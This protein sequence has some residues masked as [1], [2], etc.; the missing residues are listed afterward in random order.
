MSE[1]RNTYANGYVLWWEFEVILI[2]LYIFLNEVWR[3]EE[4]KEGVWNG[5]FG[6]W[7]GEPIRL[8]SSRTLEI[9]RVLGQVFA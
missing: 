7:K 2:L 1:D 8:I 6:E 5:R 4:D 9:G 3:S